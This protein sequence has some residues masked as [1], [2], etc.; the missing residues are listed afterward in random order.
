MQFIV[1]NDKTGISTTVNAESASEALRR[2]MTGIGLNLDMYHRSLM[3]DKASVII[4]D[5]YE[6][7]VMRAESRQ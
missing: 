3:H 7:W 4:D 1:Y 6:I 5:A 2:F